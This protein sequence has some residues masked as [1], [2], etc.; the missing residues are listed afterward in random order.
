MTERKVRLLSSANILQ[1]CTMGEAIEAARKAFILASENKVEVPAR[2]RLDVPEANGTSLIM[3]SYLPEAGKLGVKIINLYENNP[4]KGLPFSHALM[5]VFESSDGHPSGILE[6]STL[7]ALRTGAACGLATELLSR[8]DSQR[9]ALF[10]AGFQARFQLEAVVSVRKIEEVRVFDQDKERAEVFARKMSE[11][12][13]IPVRVV[14]SAQKALEAADIVSTATTSKTPVFDDR[15]IKPGVHI[16][17]IGSYKP[18]EREIPSLTVARAKIFVD[19][20][21]MAL[22]EAGDLIIP[23][24]EGLLGPEQIVA[25]LG[26]VASGKKPGRLA[27]DEITFFKTVGIAAQDIVL[28]A[29]VL[30][31]AEE[32]KLGQ[33]F[34][35]YQE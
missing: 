10:G 30:Q 14:N 8:P 16:N 2:T 20:R 25:E 35:F 7:T 18:E 27:A 29:A 13:S 17:A 21:E 6:A 24:K 32:K 22:E 12:L 15:N 34:D 26:E 4:L 28:A 1:V 9:L 31:K 33:L 5:L 23:M 3:P 11:R 19:S